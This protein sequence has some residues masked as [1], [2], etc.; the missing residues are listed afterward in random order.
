MC[1]RHVCRKAGG[2]SKSYSVSSPAAAAAAPLG[3]MVRPAAPA[4]AAPCR[5]LRGGL[6][7]AAAAAPAA[8]V[9]VPAADRPPDAVIP[10]TPEL[11]HARL[12][13]M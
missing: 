6:A 10:M 8:A 12:D 2:N 7:A 4:L 13:S 11:M 9:A 5:L 3:H 1:L